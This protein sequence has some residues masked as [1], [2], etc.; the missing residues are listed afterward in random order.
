MELPTRLLAGPILD[1]ALDWW[2]R[3]AIPVST[4]QQLFSSAHA[5]ASRAQ[6]ADTTMMPVSFVQVKSE[7]MK[8]IVDGTQ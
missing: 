2:W 8:N 4:A 1:K 5:K 7:L 3:P 6:A